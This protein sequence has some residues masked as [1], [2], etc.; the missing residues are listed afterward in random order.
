MAITRVE[1]NALVARVAA[2]EGDTSTPAVPPVVP[3]VVVPPP[4]SAIVL[5]TPVITQAGPAYS[6]T[7]DITT[8]KAATFTYLQLAVAR[9]RA[10]TEG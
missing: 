4:A 7:A 3:P 1:F 6:V 10:V 5:G 8:A 9:F 2:L